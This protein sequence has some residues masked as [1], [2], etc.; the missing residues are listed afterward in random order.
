MV[1]KGGSVSGVENRVAEG[2]QRNLLVTGLVVITEMPK[3]DGC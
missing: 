1:E 2:C 3:P